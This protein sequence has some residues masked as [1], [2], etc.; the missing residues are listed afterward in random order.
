MLS[1]DE[2]K[3]AKKEKKVLQKTRIKQPGILIPHIML[4]LTAKIW[5]VCQS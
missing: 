2:E 3:G 4:E 5:K 1:Q